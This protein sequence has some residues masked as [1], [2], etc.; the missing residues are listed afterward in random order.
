MDKDSLQLKINLWNKINDILEKKQLA[1][2]NRANLFVAFGVLISIVDVIFNCTDKNMSTYIM[3]LLYV[4]EPAIIIAFLFW[5]SMYNRTVA[6]IEGHL[7]AIEDL[8]NEELGECIYQ[9]HSYFP[10][11]YSKKCFPSINILSVFYSLVIVVLTVKCICSI[12]Q[13]S[14]MPIGVEV[15]YLS[16]FFVFFLAL[17]IELVTNAKIRKISRAFYHDNH[18][19]QL[20]CS[21]Y[22][23]MR[24]RKN[25]IK[26]LEYA[27]KPEVIAK[28]YNV[29]NK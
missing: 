29:N 5:F 24:K 18:N 19:N 2:S 8:I 12:H 20:L 27:P 1:L 10:W 3:K 11:M 16:I 21:G 7:A 26:I 28:E 25:L 17:I 9:S 14:I 6:I 4:A 23:N 22:R 13:Y 15:I